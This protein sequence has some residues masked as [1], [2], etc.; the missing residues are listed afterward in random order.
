MDI[1]TRMMDHDIQDDMVNHE[2][3]NMRNHEEIKAAV[4]TI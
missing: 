2:R 4:F 1:K 3:V